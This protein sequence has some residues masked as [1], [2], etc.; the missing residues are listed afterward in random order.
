MKGTIPI[1]TL[2][3]FSLCASAQRETLTEKLL[4]VKKKFQYE[5]VDFEDMMRR[6]FLKESGNPVEGIYSV[7]CVVSKTSKRFLSAREKT[8]IV[9]RKDNYARVAVMKDFPG[10]K[11]DFIEVSLSYRD[12]KKY[13]IVG[14]FN[15]LSD[16][17]GLIYHHLE[18][19]G[20]VIAF[21]M[22]S[23]SG[24]LM[25][26]EFSKVQRRRTITY[27]LSYLKIYPKSSPSLV[28]TEY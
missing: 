20:T 18:P 4:K 17:P 6:Y 26:G 5:E 11:R 9:Q 19:D 24:E 25:E 15:S 16:G 13:P 21:S 1:V 27:R 2:L 14:S 8:R 23:E 12:A 7:S 28:E 10:T 3:L 22:I